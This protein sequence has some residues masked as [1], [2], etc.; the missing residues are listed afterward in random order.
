MDTSEDEILR[1]L[2][3]RHHLEELTHQQRRCEAWKKITAD[4]EKL[5]GKSVQ[6]SM[7]VHDVTNLTFVTFSRAESLQGSPE[8]TPQAVSAKGQAQRTPTLQNGP[9]ENL[10]VALWS[11]YVMAIGQATFALNALRCF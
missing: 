11:H 7:T 2:I 9:H 6:L 10:G 3:N 8:T 5:S 1:C 4:F